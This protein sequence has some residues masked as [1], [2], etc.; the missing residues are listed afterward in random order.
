L[1]AVEQILDGLK[2]TNDMHIENNGLAPD[3]N[4]GGTNALMNCMSV[5][6][7]N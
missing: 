4:Y 1:I 5:I 7:H 3:A 2:T 6:T